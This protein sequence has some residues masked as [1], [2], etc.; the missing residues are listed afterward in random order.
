[1][2]PLGTHTER[3]MLLTP[4][5]R[6]R[7]SPQARSR[8]RGRHLL[9]YVIPALVV[10]AGLPVYVFPMQQTPAHAD[11]AFVLGSPD[12]WRIDLAKKLI[13]E[14]RVSA[15]LIS[16][17]SGQTPPSTCSTPM[18]FPVVC[19]RPN[20]SSTLGEARMLRTQLASHGWRTAVVITATPHI[21]RARLILHQCVAEGVSVVGRSDGIDLGEWGRQYLYQTVAMVKALVDPAC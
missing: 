18:P 11:V 16:V 5:D 1:M 14:R 3:A 20:P 12:A 8:R 21:A 7:T 13:D 15:L 9:I 2:T 10:A 19:A 4:T 6:S 17:P